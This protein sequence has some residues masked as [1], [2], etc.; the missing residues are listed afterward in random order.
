MMPTAGHSWRC[1]GQSRGSVPSVAQPRHPVLPPAHCVPVSRRF[2]C[3]VLPFSHLSNR[4]NIL[5][6]SLSGRVI[7]ICCF[8][9]PCSAICPDATHAGLRQ[10]VNVKHRQEREVKSCCCLWFVLF[11]LPGGWEHHVQ[12]LSTKMWWNFYLFSLSFFF[13]PQHIQRSYTQV[14]SQT[15][16]NASGSTA[17]WNNSECL[18]QRCFKVHSDGTSRGFIHNNNN[19][20]LLCSYRLLSIFA[21]Q[22]SIN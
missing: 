4:D 15:P 14:Y 20:T 2:R 8:K 21:T 6:T 19:I 17:A 3:P 13:L 9:C 16:A 18:Q 1:P 22:R 7:C 5:I 12:V 11:Q 10:P